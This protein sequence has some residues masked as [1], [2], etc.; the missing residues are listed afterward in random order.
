MDS[1]ELVRCPYD[2]SHQIRPS[3][4]RSHLSR[5]KVNFGKEMET[6]TCPLNPNH[7][8]LKKNMS[9]HILT[10]QD[11]LEEEFSSTDPEKLIQCPYD[12]NH[13]IRACRFPYHLIKCGKNHPDV[14]RELVTCP[15]NARHQVPRSDLSHHIANCED[16]CCIEDDIES[17]VCTNKRRG[18]TE[19]AWIPPPCEEDWDK[20][21][22]EQPASTFVW[23]TVNMNAK[24]S[25]TTSQTL[26]HRSHL[27]SG[28]R[29]PKSLPC[30]L[31]WKK[32]PA[33]LL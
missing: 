4:F 13:Q 21:L 30:T 29:A 32:W 2:P 1:E 24:Q 23:G 5:C 26:G 8:V 10:S 17:Q 22:E 28:M 20:E 7:Q 9:R 18:A 11:S 33:P 27:A 3:H 12:K 6:V 25:A 15:F 19:N 16:R 14:V 31:P